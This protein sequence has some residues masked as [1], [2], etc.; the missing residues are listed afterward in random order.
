MHICFSNHIS[1]KLINENRGFPRNSIINSRENPRKVTFSVS[2]S[3]RR[4]QARKR[5]NYKL[6][7]KQEINIKKSSQFSPAK[8]NQNSPR[9]VGFF[10]QFTR[11]FLRPYAEIEKSPVAETVFKRVQPFTCEWLLRPKVALSELSETL[12][13]NVD[14]IADKEQKAVTA[15]AVRKLV[16]GTKSL[17]KS[18]HVLHKGHVSSA[19]EKDVIDTL[20]ELFQ[21]DDEL[22]SVLEEM[23]HIG[24]AMFVT[25][26]HVIVAK[27]LI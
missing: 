23:F 1:Y 11:P 5:K 17:R 15:D 22:D 12:A 7:N 26:T 10:Q 21:E 3:S 9:S 24:A 18:L 14:V 4:Q 6:E 16:S 2:S 27:A 13:K 8:H 25:A 20:K 19:K